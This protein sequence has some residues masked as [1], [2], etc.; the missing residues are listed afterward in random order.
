MLFSKS[1]L[2][3]PLMGGLVLCSSSVSALA[4]TSIYVGSDLTADGS[5]IFARSEDIS[6]SYNKLFYV[7]PAGTHTAGETYEGCYGFTYEFTHD[8]YSYTAF[9]DDNGDGADGVCPDCGSAHAHTPYQA[10]GTNEMGVTVSATET[11]G[12]SDAVYEVDPYEDLGIEEAEIVTVLLSEAGSAREAVD[13]LLNIYD[14]V[15]CCGGSGLFIADNNETWYIE[16]T[17]GHQYIALKLSDSM[18][19]TQPNM[20]VI[21]LIDLDDTENVIA[22]EN[23]IAVAQEAGTYVGDAQENT[24]DYVASYN[25]DQTANG[26][27]IDALKYF[28]AD[29]ASEEPAASDYTISNVDAEGNIVPMYTNITLDHDYSIEDVV[30]FYHI[31]SIGYTRNLET[32]IF[33]ISEEDSITDTV[34]W[35]AMDDASY[36]VFIPYYPMLT[37]NTYD[38][39]QVSTAASVFTEEEPTDADLYYPTTTTVRDGDERVTVE[40]FCA[41][42]ENWADSFYWTFDALSNLVEFGSLSEEQ[43]DNINTT[44]NDLQTQCYDVYT[45]LQDAVASAETAEA[46]AE[47]VTEISAD[48]AADVHAAVVELV[49]GVK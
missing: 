1:K 8:S 37:T 7:S 4:C 14:T 15:G 46:A 26:R 39:Y 38:G 13:L 12:S 29:E 36:S 25:G 49:N 19:F 28:N 11:I 32:H 23:L 18:V 9:S 27:M 47:T 30:E 20:S 34:E 48:A 33:Q 10:G 42:P 35:V 41:L 44:L 2:L 45:E 6:N 5:T 43:I 3:I 21:G 22:S 40:G 16:N 17:T 31:S 24:I